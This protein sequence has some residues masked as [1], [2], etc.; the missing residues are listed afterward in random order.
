MPPFSKATEKKKKTKLN[1]HLQFTEAIFSLSSMC[2]YTQIHTPLFFLHFHTHF[3]LLFLFLSTC[4]AALKPVGSSDLK[5]LSLFLTPSVLL[6]ILVIRQA[7]FNHSLQNISVERLLAVAEELADHLAAQ[8]LPLQQEVCDAYRCIRN[9]TSRDEK[10]EA[11]I[12]ISVQEKKKK[13]TI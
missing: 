1:E 13:D 11:F 3:Y 4:P 9:K 10:L 2:M 7:Y 5:R 6:N 8:S 12:W